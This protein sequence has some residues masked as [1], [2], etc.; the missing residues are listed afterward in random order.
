MVLILRGN[1][2]FADLVK[3]DKYPSTILHSLLL[4]IAVYTDTLEKKKGCIWVIL[5]LS[6]DILA[7]EQMVEI[8]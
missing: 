3:L 8:K 7:E 2:S 1:I 6:V 4:L 5:P